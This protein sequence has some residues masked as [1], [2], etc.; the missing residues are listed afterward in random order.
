MRWGKRGG[1]RP[2]KEDGEEEEREEGHMLRGR[3]LERLNECQ[4]IGRW[5]AATEMD[6]VLKRVSAKLS[7]GLCGE[8][9]FCQS[10]TVSGGGR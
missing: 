3:K 7:T 2:E 4:E 10:Q 8:A 9:E 1:K 6:A 5:R